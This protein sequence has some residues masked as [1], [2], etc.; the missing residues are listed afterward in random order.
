LAGRD[1]ASAMGASGISLL[2][3]C[4]DVNVF[5]R[6]CVTEEQ[7]WA[8]V[9]FNTTLLAPKYFGTRRH[10]H[11]QRHAIE[12][13]KW[14]ASIFYHGIQNMPVQANVIHAEE[15]ISQRQGSLRSPIS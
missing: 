2:A 8:G 5:D 12:V 15:Y 14:V 11:R 9:G 6:G 13:E 1:T 7:T 3:E 10:A 4:E